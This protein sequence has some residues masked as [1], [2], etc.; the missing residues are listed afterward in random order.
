MTRFF[1]GAA[2][3]Q[4]PPED[5]LRQAVEAEQAGFD[6][7]SASDHLAPWFE[8]GQGGATWPWLGAAGHATKS[9]PLG[10]GVTSTAARYHPALI[11]QAWMTLERMFPGRMFLGLGSGEALNE[12]P[13]GDAWPTVGKQIARMDE[14]LGIIDR[15]WKGETVTLDGTYYACKDCRLHTLA[16]RRPPLWIS[17][18][19][20][21]AAKVA[22]R[23]G[24]GVWSLGDP[25]KVP[26]VLESYRAARSSAGRNADGDGEVVLQALV[27]WA[28]SDEEA[29]ESARGWKATQPP[30][31]YIDPIHRPAD[32]D[33]LGA[34][35]ISDA[36]FLES[37]LISHDPEVH[38]EKLRELIAL[39]ATVIVC[40]FVS[41]ADP[42]GAIRFYGER[43]LPALR[44]AR[45]G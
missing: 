36:A 5:L 33:A 43:V 28:P 25:E 4:F 7:I 39:G 41:P 1:Y 35:K 40:Q 38:V 15:L 19:G 34:E 32:L 22:G 44:G 12:V 27:S 30:E 42:H 10:T 20:P 6:G 2:F 45:V 26:A 11:A 9:A 37:A 24:D 13:V 18:F 31:A 3:E 23:W 17:A 16:E 21:Q 14:A 8:G 29:L